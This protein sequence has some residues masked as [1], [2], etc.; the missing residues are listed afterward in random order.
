MDIHASKLQENLTHHSN[1]VRA[2]QLLYTTS[3]LCGDSTVITLKPITMS[4]PL[5]IKIQLNGEYSNVGGGGARVLTFTEILLSHKY[6]LIRSVSNCKNSYT[7]INYQSLSRNRAQRPNSKKH[8]YTDIYMC[9][10]R[11]T[12]NILFP[13]YQNLGADS[14]NLDIG[15]KYTGRP[16]WHYREPK[17]LENNQLKGLWGRLSISIRNNVESVKSIY[18]HAYL[19]FAVYNNA[20]NFCERRRLHQ[21]KQIFH[22]RKAKILISKLKKKI[23]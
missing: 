15:S 1:L 6:L 3:I 8:C 19:K 2:K 23:I 11:I 4:G 14:I 16:K 17:H 20:L 5:N 9:P 12:N 7:T 21:H 22:S 13:C 18:A 10:L